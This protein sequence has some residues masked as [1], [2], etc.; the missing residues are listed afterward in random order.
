MKKVESAFYI[1]GLAETVLLAVEQKIADRN[2]AF[3]QRRNYEF[4]L[5]RRN[6]PSPHRTI[7]GT[8]TSASV[9]DRCKAV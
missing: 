2:A 9:H 8:Q 1:L 4:G 3:L 5:V 7:K 6:D